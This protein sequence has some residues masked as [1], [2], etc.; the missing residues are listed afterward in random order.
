MIHGGQFCLDGIEQ[1]HI[2]VVEM[3][4]STREKS[5]W[6]NIELLICM[7]DDDERDIDFRK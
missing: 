5:I 3:A 2:G 7:E 1:H 6:T 4:S